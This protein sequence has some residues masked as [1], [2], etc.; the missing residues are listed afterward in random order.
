[1]SCT[2]CSEVF[3]CRLLFYTGRLRVCNLSK[4]L[5]VE[6][7]K[8]HPLQIAGRHCN[9]RFSSF[10]VPVIV[11]W[12]VK[13]TSRVL[14]ASGAYPS[15]SIHP[16]VSPLPPPFAMQRRKWHESRYEG[17]VGLAALSSEVPPSVGNTGE[18]GQQ[19]RERWSDPIYKCIPPLPVCTTQISQQ[20][21]WICILMKTWGIYEK[22]WIWLSSLHAQGLPSLLLEPNTLTFFKAWRRMPG[23]GAALWLCFCLRARP[24]F[25]FGNQIKECKATE[26]ETEPTSK[27]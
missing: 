4:N 22:C 2:W 3:W 20:R 24:S 15:F 27:R 10:L 8:N 14:A 1:M 13:V 6:F 7:K 25:H 19:E 21:R 23:F 18:W 26:Q 5:A 12:V 17:R 16:F 11:N 9:V